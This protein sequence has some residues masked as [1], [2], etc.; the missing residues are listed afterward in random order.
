[1]AARHERGNGRPGLFPLEIWRVDP[2][3]ASV[4]FRV[5]NMTITT[6]RGRFTAFLGS[7]EAGELGPL[8]ASGTIRSG[9]AGTDGANCEERLPSVDFFAAA[10]DP[11][12]SFASTGIAPLTG[13][14]FSVAGELTIGNRT[15][16]VELTGTVLGTRL[17]PWGAEHVALE[18]RGEI[19]C[20]ELGPTWNEAL[21][22]GGVLVGEEVQIEL[23]LSA[24]KPA[25]HS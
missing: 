24:P 3:H 1:M 16:P 7:V 21:E 5:E 20:T 18:L 10:A 19:D 6:V 15:R 9:N 2:A 4:E 25:A 14:D 17:D 22:T 13:S 12:L 11:Q 8:K 23:E